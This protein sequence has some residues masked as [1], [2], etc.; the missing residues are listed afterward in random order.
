MS[1][2][3][4]PSVFSRMA[5]VRLAL[6]L[7]SMGAMLLLPWNSGGRLLPAIKADEIP[8]AVLAYGLA[9]LAPVFF[10]LV[11]IGTV[12]H[13]R[14]TDLQPSAPMR[15]FGLWLIDL[16]W[17]APLL[18]A[19]LA[20]PLMMSSSCGEPERPARVGQMLSFGSCGLIVLLSL[21]VEPFL[22]FRALRMRQREAIA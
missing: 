4:V 16:V 7:L 8:S 1:H 22:L 14:R 19:W 11:S 9:L 13:L 15:T 10:V 2:D 20:I 6:A 3:H 18:L 21:M 5:V 12:A 17:Q